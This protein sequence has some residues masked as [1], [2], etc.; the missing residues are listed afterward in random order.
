MP[1][2][3][4]KTLLVCSSLKKSSYHLAGKWQPET[5]LSR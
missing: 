4:F 5:W 1:G 3:H 2:I